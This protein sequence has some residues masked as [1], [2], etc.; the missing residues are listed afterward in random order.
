V[1]GAAVVAAAR[2]VVKAAR[3]WRRQ[4][5]QRGRLFDRGSEDGCGE[6]GVARGGLHTVE[7]TVA[8]WWRGHGAVSGASGY[9]SGDSSCSEG[10]G[11]GSVTC[12]VMAPRVA[13]RL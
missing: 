9:A 13:W 1:V 5:R 2:A 7:R 3:V 6:V 10:S 11:A 12:A 4:R 8:S